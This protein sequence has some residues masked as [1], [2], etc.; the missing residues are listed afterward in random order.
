MEKQAKTK[1]A[2]TPANPRVYPRALELHRALRELDPSFVS[3]LLEA[4]KE[5]SGD[6]DR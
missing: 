5:R 3:P 1:Q 4:E 2:T 6:A